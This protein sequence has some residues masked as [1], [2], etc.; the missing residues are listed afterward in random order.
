MKSASGYRW[1]YRFQSCG[2]PKKMAPVKSSDV[3][4]DYGYGEINNNPLEP[5]A[6]SSA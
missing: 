5:A 6:T 4:P 2:E 3:L 1:Q